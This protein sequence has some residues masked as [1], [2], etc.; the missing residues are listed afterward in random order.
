M[1]KARVQACSAG[2]GGINT[3][4][5]NVLVLSHGSEADFPQR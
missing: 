5:C 2:R 3:L 4:A 1:G